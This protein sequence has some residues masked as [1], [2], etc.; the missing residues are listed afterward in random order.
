MSRLMHIY[1]I[2]LNFDLIARRQ[3]RIESSNQIPVTLEQV[4]NSIDR[5]RSVDAGTEQ[6]LKKLTS[7]LM[8]GTS[9][10]SEHEIVDRRTGDN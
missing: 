3:E 4:R 8:L 2:S 6:T 9:C 1:F 10:Y 7:G 5:S